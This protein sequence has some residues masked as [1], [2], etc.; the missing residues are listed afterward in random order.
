MHI[1]ILLTAAFATLVTA[2]VEPTATAVAAA[3][4][5]VNQ[6][7]ES[8][9]ATAAAATITRSTTTTKTKRKK[10]TATAT[11]QKKG[12][13]GERFVYSGL[14]FV[15]RVLLL[16]WLS[17]AAAVPL[18]EF[19]VVELKTRQPVIQTWIVSFSQI[20]HSERK[21]H[22]SSTKAA[23]GDLAINQ[24]KTVQSAVLVWSV[25][26]QPQC[27]QGNLGLVKKGLETLYP[28]VEFVEAEQPMSRVAN[29]IWIVFR[30][31]NGPGPKESA[32]S[33]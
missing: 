23:L 9:T 17:M 11:K 1:L 31:I 18:A 2:Q 19:A 13:A 22:V 15:V 16:L 26:I 30:R 28:S 4:T 3:T 32:P 10:K 7:R 21:E 25:L 33:R 27:A 24:F 12:S 5:S 29:Q 14:A 6:V 20:P 8:I